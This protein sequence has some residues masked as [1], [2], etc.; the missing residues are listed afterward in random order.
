MCIRDSN[1][2]GVDLMY[3]SSASVYG[4]T[5]D[6]TPN[7][8]NNY[9]WTKYLF[10]RL[11][12]QNLNQKGSKI[13]IEVKGLRLFNVWGIPEAE[14]HKGSQASLMTQFHNKETVKLFKGSEG[15]YRDFIHV[16]DVC[17]IIISLLNVPKSGFYDVG[18]GTQRSFL[19]VANVLVNSDQY[20]PTKI[21]WIEFPLTLIGKYQDNTK[22]YNAKLIKEIGPIKFRTLEDIDQPNDFIADCGKHISLSSNPKETELN[23]YHHAKKHA[24]WGDLSKH[25]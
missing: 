24:D 11:V 17:S 14:M 9:A 7:P 12:E 25:V 19:D 2:A 16:S 22:A 21:E 6:N 8:L 3:A 20:M 23:E 15:I 18:T 4:L 10:D 1:Q 5:E 13:N